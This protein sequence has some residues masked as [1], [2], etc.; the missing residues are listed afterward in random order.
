MTIS[1]NDT[2]IDVFYMGNYTLRRKSFVEMFC[3]T[4]C[5]AETIYPTLKFSNESLS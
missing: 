1:I 3:M 2:G 4:P 5:L